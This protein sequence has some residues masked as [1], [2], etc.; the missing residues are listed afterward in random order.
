MHL[1]DVGVAELIDQS[2]GAVFVVP[3]DDLVPDGQAG[4]DARR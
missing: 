1:S 2:G 3:L 4:D